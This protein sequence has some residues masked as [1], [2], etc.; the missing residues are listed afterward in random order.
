V[1]LIEDTPTTVAEAYASPDVEY[2]KNAV[3]SEMDFITA[4]GTRA[5]IDRPMGCKPVWL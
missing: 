3:H 1:Y 4:N 5:V 2:W